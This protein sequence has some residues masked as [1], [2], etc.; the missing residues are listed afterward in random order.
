[1]F[2]RKVKGPVSVNLP[3]G[4]KMTR[5]D[6]PARTTRRWVASRKA[7]VVKA[8]KYGLIEVEEALELYGLSVEELQSW[9]IAVDKYGQDAL[10]LLYTS[11]AADD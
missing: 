11:D 2:V 9:A 8:I 7:A 5:S 4:E 3:N 1:M 10:C 6:L